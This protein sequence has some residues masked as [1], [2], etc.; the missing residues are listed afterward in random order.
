MHRHDDHPITLA[1]IQLLQTLVQNRRSWP[2][3][4]L[5][6]HRLLHLYSFQPQRLP[7][8]HF[9]PLCLAHR[10]HILQPP[11][12]HQLIPRLQPQLLERTLHHHP[13]PDDI[14][15]TDPP[16]LRQIGFRKQP[17]D[18][19]RP[20]T[21]KRPRQI[22]L[23]LTLLQQIGQ[24]HPV[25]QQ[26]RRQH[27]QIQ[28]THR[29]HR[30]TQPRDLEHTERDVVATGAGDIPRRPHHHHICRRPYQ[31]DHPPRHRRKGKRDQQLRWRDPLPAA[32]SHH[33]RQKND[34]YRRVVQKSRDRA[35]HQHQHPQ[36]PLRALPRPSLIKRPRRRHQ[37]RLL[38]RDTDH[39]HPRDHHHRLIRKRPHRRLHRQH[40]RQHHRRKRQQRRNFR[41]DPLAHEGHKHQHHNHRGD[42]LLVG[43]GKRE[44]GN[45]NPAKSVAEPAL[46]P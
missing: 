40:P 45:H 5:H 7:R 11:L 9:Q 12:Q 27:P 21:D 22:L 39:Q 15:Q 8:H 26:A 30:Q 41:S 43:L 1:E 6:H 33:H 18:Q 37:P 4:R 19:C 44:D 24:C 32:G 46:Q 35:T 36:A 38:H 28:Q 2:Q 31:R 3:H 29:K 34:H 16:Q 17:A 42:D 23:R 13:L 10:H 25:R 14:D 20:L